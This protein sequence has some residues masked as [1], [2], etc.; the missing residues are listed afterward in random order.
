MAEDELLDA[1]EAQGID[2]GHDPDAT[3]VD[4]LDEDAELVMPLIDER[5]AWIPALLDG[6]TFIHRLNELEVEHDIVRWDTDL[7]PVSMLTESETYQRL[8]DGFA[9]HRC[10]PLPGR[11]CF[12][13]ATRT[14]NSDRRRGSVA[15]TARI[16]R[17]TWCR[18]R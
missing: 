16:L 3:L 5:W 15:A 18:R 4:V 2:L 8:V 9:D 10:V 14:R 17:R 11:R 1:L 6:R 7:A 13:G 12:G